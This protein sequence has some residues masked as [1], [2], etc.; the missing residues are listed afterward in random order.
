MG[1]KTQFSGVY[2]LGDSV[3]IKHSKESGTIIGRAEYPH[4][5][6]TYLIRYQA[7]DGRAVEAWWNESAIAPV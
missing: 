5:E 4:S 6:C 1:D 7:A 3:K 2:A